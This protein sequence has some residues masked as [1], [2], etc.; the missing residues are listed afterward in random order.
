M[1]NKDKNPIFYKNSDEMDK[2]LSELI[3]EL[4]CDISKIRGKLYDIR[5]SYGWGDR[6][7]H[8]E[9]G[10]TCILSAMYLTMQEFK[11]F[12]DKEKEKL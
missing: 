12:E 3:E 9:G 8:I 6:I 2:P 5:N 11:L 7:E 1:K 4:R 10:L